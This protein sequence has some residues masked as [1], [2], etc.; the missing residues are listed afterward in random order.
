MTENNNRKEHS[1]LLPLHHPQRDF[2][3]CDIFDAAPKSDMVSMQYPLFSLST[4]PDMTSRR[5]EH[6]NNW[7]E[8]KPSFIGLATVFDRDVLI[9]CISQCMVALNKG[10]R[11]HRKMRFAVHD[12][13]KATNRA[14]NDRGYQ[15]LRAA[16]ERLR[17]THIETNIAMGDHEYLTGFGFIDS[18]EIVK[19]TREG[20]MQAV[21]ITL[22]EWIFDAI[23][24]KGDQI[25]T[26]SPRYFQLRKLN[27]PGFAGGSFS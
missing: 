6:G 26:I 9:Y 21:E 24:A 15:L 11:V 23:D 25:L 16:L 27:R 20:R 7:I 22:S 13:L 14:T 10:K 18:Y 3:V 2:F 17:A 1:P 12:L 19:E 8:L 4:K 5:Y